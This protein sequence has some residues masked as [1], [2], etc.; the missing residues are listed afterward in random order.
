MDGWKYVQFGAAFD[1]GY[2]H[3]TFSDDAY[4]VDTL[5]GLTITNPVIPTEIGSMCPKCRDEIKSR[6]TVLIDI[7]VKSMR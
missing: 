1:R 4:Q 2:V 6:L 3:I 5:C 7:I